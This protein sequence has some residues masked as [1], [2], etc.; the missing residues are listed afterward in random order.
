MTPNTCID[1]RRIWPTARALKGWMGCLSRGEA[2][3]ASKMSH[4]YNQVTFRGQARQPKARFGGGIGGETCVGTC[5]ACLCA[6]GSASSRRGDLGGV[7]RANGEGCRFTPWCANPCLIWSPLLSGPAPDFQLPNAPFFNIYAD[8]PLTTN[9]PSLPGGPCNFVDLTPGAGGHK[10]GCRRFWSRT[11]F[12]G[13]ER[14]S[15]IGF[16]PGFANGYEDQT[17]W[18]MCSHHACYHD[19]TRDSQT[20]VPTPVVASNHMNGQENERP[21][22]NREPLT[23]VIPGLS[24]NLPHSISQD[25]EFN[26]IT[27]PGSVSRGPEETA[28]PSGIVTPS[29]PDTLAWASLIQSGPNRAGSLPPIPSQCLM[30][31]QPSSTTSSARIAYLKP[32]AGKGLQTLSGVRSITLE[33]LQEQSNAAEPEDEDTIDPDCDH[34]VDDQTVTNTPRSTRHRDTTD[35]LAQSPTP[36]VN[37]EVFHLLSNTV[38]GHEQRIENLESI[39]FS[40]AAH[41]ICHEKHDQADLRVTELESRV[42]EVEKILNDN[43]SHA[44]GYSWSRRDRIGDTTASVVSVA[45]STSNYIMDR[46]ELQSELQTLR[47][48]L[49]QL[50]DISSFP[51]LIRPWKVEVVFLPFPLKNVWLKSHDFGSQR[52]SH[53]S[54]SEADL[55]TQFPNSIEPQSPGF[56]DWAGPEVD[57]DWLLGRACAADNMIGQRLRSRGLV[58]NVTV[59]G[60]DA[61]S[62]Q[63]A[64]SEAFGTLFRT[65]SRMQANV[66]HGSTI[67]H[68][69]TKFL[70]LQ[71]PWVPLRK[72][73]KDS[74]LRFLTPAEMVTPVSWNVQFLASS[75]VMKSH[76]I[77]RLFITH[78]EAY[79]QD[80]DA[81]ENGWTWQRLRELS[82][83]YADSQSSQEIL[84]G[85]AKEE[86]WAWNDVLDEPPASDSHIFRAQAAQASAQEHWRAVS[87]LSSSR[88]VFVSARATTPSPATRRSASR[89]QSPAVI[90]DRRASKPPRI[91]TTSVPPALQALVS[92]AIAKRRVTPQGPPNERYVSPQTARAA[93][94]AALSKRRSRRSPSVRQHLNR[95]TPRWS[96]A[97]PS[98]APEI[99]VA[100]G[101]SPFYATPY[102]NAPFVDTRPG[103]GGVNIDNDDININFYAESDS[104]VD[105]YEDEAVSDDN[106]E[107]LESGVDDDD[108]SMAD[109]G[110][111]SHHTQLNE[112][113]PN[114]QA[115]EDEAWLGIEDAE[116]RDPDVSI[117]VDDDAMTDDDTAAGSRATDPDEHENHSQGSSVPSEY[118]SN[119]PWA[120]SGRE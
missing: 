99:F 11:S 41:D 114:G 86:C 120:A 93:Q 10:C 52:L 54:S 16:P 110:H 29:L 61:R 75:V 118:P 28:R 113:W 77:H 111:D 49:S 35:G 97:S 106:D 95:F 14:G 4:H 102:S 68:R 34:F 55:W 57:S 87:H 60:P 108:S 32:F 115:P 2:A 30:P 23:P 17:Y 64:M 59:R 45:T 9:T 81:Y 88:D 26:S 12:A 117:H 62:V 76:G 1:S 42:E 82:R 39:S 22:T 56:C 69:V 78:P 63:Q 7:Y 48:E 38:Q 100:R 36:G 21:R 94:V 84:E 53:G 109:L 67:H 92:P 31:S 85:D 79:L 43:A 40:A 51:S 74:R 15:P 13:S 83:V 6:I 20:P 24:F 105:V 58:K 70:G 71:S 37:R 72:L 90:Q 5:R 66:H 65:F 116:N 47:A 112:S 101:I 8:V 107:Q 27:N 44:S 80:Q 119:Q 46:A 25:M 96:T 91:R 104:D 3:A 73:H 19:D 103:R 50:Q 33:P 18:C 98:P 89:A